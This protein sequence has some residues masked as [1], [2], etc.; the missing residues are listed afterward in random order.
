[1][2]NAS[3]FNRRTLLAG[4]TSLCAASIVPRHVLGG[5]GQTPPSEQLNVAV[6]G[7]GGQGIV[8]LRNLLQHS[9]VNIVAIC[10]VA[11]F[12]DN[13]QIYYRHNG[14]R[15]PAM[16]AIEEHFQE[17]ATT[18]NWLEANRARRLPEHA[19]EVGP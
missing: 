16:K 10:D 1:M 3:R 8:N 12:W 14:G 5:P 6:I 9:D 15:G 4:G 7:T 2:Q 13:S 17:K 18:K 19:Q 11:E